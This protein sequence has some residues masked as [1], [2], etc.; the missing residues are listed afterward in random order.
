MCVWKGTKKKNCRGE[1]KKCEKDGKREGGMG[2]EGRFRYVKSQRIKKQRQKKR[3]TE[4]MTG[5]GY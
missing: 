1:E 5:L 4:G 3:E 2:R